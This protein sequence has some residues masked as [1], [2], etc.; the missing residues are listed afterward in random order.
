MT[1]EFQRLRQCN[2]DN[3]PWKKWGPYL[4]ERQWGTVRED[5]SPDGEAWQ[6]FP[7]FQSTA[8]AY[9]WGEDGLAG[10]SDDRQQLCFALALWNGRDPVL[11]ERLFGLTGTQGN[12]GEDVKEYYFYLD[13][14]PTHS[15]LKYLYKYPQAPFPYEDLVTTNNQRSKHQPEYELLDTGVFAENRYFDIFVEYAKA[16]PEDILIQISVINRG[17][18]EAQ[19]RVLPTLWFRNTWS[20]EPDAAKPVL[21]QCQSEDGDS[22]VL[23]S[24]HQ[25]GD[26]Q[27]FCADNPGLLFTDNETNAQRLFAGTNNGP[28]VK[29]GINEYVLHGNRT[30]VNADGCGTKMAAD[31]GLLIAAG[32]TRVIR[33]RLVRAGSIESSTAFTDFEMVFDLRRQQADLFYQQLSGGKLDTEKQRLLRQMLAGM[34][35]T[36]QYYEFDVGRWLDE[37]HGQATRNADWGHMKNRD[38]ISMPDKWEYPWYAVWD[39]A[40]HTLPL[41]MVDPVFAKHQLSL[42]LE[43]RYLHPSGQMPAYEWNFSD[44]NPPVH[45]WATYAVY[46]IDRESHGQGDLAFLKTAFAGLERNFHWWETRKGPD[47]NVYQ[48]GFLGLDN[49]GVF[50][51]SHALPTG[52]HLEQSDG[53]AWMTL[54]AQNM[55][56]IA[57]ELS[58]HDLDYEHKVITYLDHFLAIAAAMHDIGSEHRDMWDEDDGFFYDVLRFPDGHS[59]RLKIRS[60]VGLLPLCAVTV[61]EQSALQKLPQV[62]ARFEA[63]VRHK[64]HLTTD[65]FCPIKPGMGG[66][67]L[68]AILDEEKLRRVL[69]RLLDEQE[70]L[71]PYGIRSLSKYHQA[72]PYHFHW[73]DQT[74]TVSYQ[75]GESDSYMFG[76]NSNWR[77]PVWIPANILIIRALLSLYT[78]YGDDFQIECPTT[79][80]TPRNLFQIAEMIAERLLRIF[81]PD[82]QGRRAVFGGSEKFQTDPHWQDHLLFYEYFH[83]EDG[84]GLGASH[85]TGWTGALATLLTIFGSLAPADLSAAGMRRV[86]ATLGG[87][88]RID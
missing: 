68:L 40:F 41:A 75:P 71:S 62:A 57:L 44:V 15:Y 83:G 31:Y 49:I 84:S 64:N 54:Y 50:D 61:I 79:T 23:A 34:L 55:L 58:L 28:Y 5:Y 39:T 11:K 47:G 60:L 14:T 2:Q 70:F 59:T 48:G 7:H 63:L 13:A 20:W 19:L 3:V 53:T 66:R 29:D 10:I 4:S 35:W 12:H 27:L 51:R 72:H 9:R 73:Q 21:N 77:G 33:L 6:Y 17:P 22:I 88:P 1:N 45:A 52:G 80:G 18:E 32:E 36:K 76:G 43:E 46:Q 65:I 81:L 38:I 16:D 82:E 24:H 85:Q 30:A 56:Q 69:A 87:C 78:Y 8:R 67:R 42:F 26:Y 37:H 25:L 86:T 74:F